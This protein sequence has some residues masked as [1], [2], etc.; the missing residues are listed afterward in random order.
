MKIKYLS[1]DT[2]M[3]IDIYENIDRHIDISSNSKGYWLAL[4]YALD[5]F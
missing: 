1:V 5:W 2:G 4:I 3:G